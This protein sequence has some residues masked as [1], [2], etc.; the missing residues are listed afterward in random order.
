[1]RIVEWGGGR[2]PKLL[3]LRCDSWAGLLLKSHG[4]CGQQYK[5]SHLNFLSPTPTHI[6]T[7]QVR[8]VIEAERFMTPRINLRPESVST[9][10]ADGQVG[11]GPRSPDG[12]PF[13]FEVLGTAGTESIHE[14]SA[15]AA[16]SSLDNSRRGGSTSLETCPPPTLDVRRWTEAVGSDFMVRGASYLATRVKVPSAKQVRVVSCFVGIGWVP[17]E[18]H[19]QFFLSEN[20]MKVFVLYWPVCDH[21]SSLCL[22]SEGIV[23][24]SKEVLC[25]DGQNDFRRE[26]NRSSSSYPIQVD[27]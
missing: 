11:V 25:A 1:M 15:T 4:A 26:R 24:D 13:L 5:R 10:F 23:V 21:G 19:L 22:S 16:E 27:R 2:L 12:R 8:D 9:G 6:S 7:I 3:V 20:L 18:R 17:L 14:A